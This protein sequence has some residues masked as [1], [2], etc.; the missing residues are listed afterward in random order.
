MRKMPLFVVGSMI[1]AVLLMGV[2]TMGVNA[3]RLPELDT[4]HDGMDDDWEINYGLNVTM[5]DASED[6][7]QDGMTNIE[8]FLGYT[9]PDNADDSKRVHDNRM[10]VFIGVA[11]AMGI[12]AIMSSIGIG[13][14]GAGATGVVA[15]RPDKFGR[16][17]VYQALPMTQGI[18]GLLV[19]IL[20]LFFTG[21]TEGPNIELLSSPYVGWGALAIGLVIAL[22]SVSAIPQGMTAS[23]AAAAFGRNNNVFG[24]GVI[25]AV[26]SE[27]MAIFGFLVAIFLLLASG[28]LG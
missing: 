1:A 11:I 15:E 16:L 14:A 17:I 19:S 25:F 9:N 24:K 22:S 21:L 23:A 26:M 20:V 7:D 12:A 8:E 27:T 28:M 4:D 13:I 2:F 3:E 10:L 6:K 18:Y 5:N